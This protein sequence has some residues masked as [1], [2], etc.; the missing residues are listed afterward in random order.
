MAWPGTRR[1][2]YVRSRT[3]MK[4]RLLCWNQ[5]P[6]LTEIKARHAEADTIF[7]TSVDTPWHLWSALT[8][9]HIAWN[10][11]H[12]LPKLDANIVVTEQKCNEQPRKAIGDQC[13]KW[14]C[15]W[16]YVWFFTIIRSWYVLIKDVLENSAVTDLSTWR[17]A[18]DQG[19]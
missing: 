15:R 12:I 18:S 3:S 10:Q 5:V 19:R 11:P 8:A 6:R 16:S 1:T 7:N 13:S 17:P 2:M 9:H 4:F 14:I